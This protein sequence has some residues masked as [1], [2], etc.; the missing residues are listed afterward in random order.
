MMKSP[1]YWTSH[2]VTSTQPEKVQQAL[3]LAVFT[4]GAESV[5][6]VYFSQIRDAANILIS[7]GSGGHAYVFA[8]LAYHLHLAGYSVFIMPKQGGRTVDQL[9]A[10]H[11]T[12]L[13]YIASE[14]N[15]T[16]GAYGEGLGGYVVFYLALGHAPVA[17]IACQNSPAIMT[18]PR[19]HEALLSDSRPWTRSVRRRRIMMPIATRLASVTPHLQVPLS[20]YL[21]W[22]DP[23]LGRRIGP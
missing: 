18:E 1:D 6:L 20:S 9:L 4:R 15:E 11:R 21:P 8:E 2:Y 16:I 19:Y 23:T 12:A 14:F 3:K 10:R 17:S 13:H 22:K 7:P 5:E